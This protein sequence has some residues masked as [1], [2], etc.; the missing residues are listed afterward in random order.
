MIAL[1]FLFT[2]NFFLVVLLF[3]LKIS[4]NIL[5]NNNLLDNVLDRKLLFLTT[6]NIDDA[7]IQLKRLNQEFD[8]IKEVRID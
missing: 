2:F 4:V 3:Y 6:N 8:E 5:N 1:L 7:K